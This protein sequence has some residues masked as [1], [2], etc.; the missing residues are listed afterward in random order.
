MKAGDEL[1]ESANDAA[2]RDKQW[3][4]VGAIQILCRSAHISD[5]EDATRLLDEATLEPLEPHDAAR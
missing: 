1:F 3:A 5:I 2:H 4:L